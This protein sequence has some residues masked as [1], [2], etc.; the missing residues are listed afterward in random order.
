VKV[1]LA[2]IFFTLASYKIG[3]ADTLYQAAPTPTVGHPLHLGADHKASQVGDL[4]EV[5]FNFSVNSSNSQQTST[6]D[7]RKMSVDPG[8][9]LANISLLRFGAGLSS[10]QQSS[11]AKSNSDQNVFI[12]TMEAQVTDVLPSGSLKIAGDQLLE[13]NGQKQTLHITGTIRPEDIAS[14]D[15]IVSTH[16]ANVQAAFK[17]SLQ[18]KNQ[19]LI[20]RILNFLF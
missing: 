14:D 19:G 4:V 1:F 3:C 6:N 10:G 16:V 5:V 18:P 9:G 20:Q 15:S 2:V 17:G 8:T 12:S 7:S 11:T 13:I